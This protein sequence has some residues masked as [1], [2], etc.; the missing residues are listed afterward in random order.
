MINPPGNDLLEL[1]C[2][3]ANIDDPKPEDIEN[4]GANTDESFFIED[5][6]KN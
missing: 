1:F 4:Y 5:Y 6:K 2:A 3:P